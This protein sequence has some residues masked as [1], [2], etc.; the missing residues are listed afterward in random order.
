[1]FH[2]PL[3]HHA[4]RFLAAVAVFV[5]LAVPAHAENEANQGPLDSLSFLVGQ[6]FRNTVD[7]RDYAFLRWRGVPPAAAS[8]YGKPGLPTAAGTFTMAGTLAPQI[9]PTVIATYAN[10]MPAQVFD[11]VS[12][13]NIIDS[14][15]GEFIPAFDL[16]LA[17]KLAMLILLGNDDPR[18]RQR[19]ESLSV[20]EPFLAVCMGLAAV[21]PMP[22]AITTFELR[23]PEAVIARVTVQTQQGS[24]LPAPPAPT[25][26]LESG[27]T[28]HLNVKLRWND[29]ADMLR[30]TPQSFGFDVFRIEKSFAESVDFHL[31]PPAQEIVIALRNDMPGLVKRINEGAILI[32]ART[33]PQASFIADDN[34]ALFGE[35][36]PFA[37]GDAFYYYVAMRD[38]L[39]NPGPLSP[40]TLVTICKRQPPES[41][42]RV[43]VSNYRVTG[44]IVADSKTH[45]RVSWRPHPSAE[46]N[47][48]RGY[49]ISRWT[50]VADI[51]GG[52][53]L[54]VSA[55]EPH[56]PGKREYQF[57]DQEI[58]G[59]AD[60]A[61]TFWYSVE[62][63][64]ET[65]C[66]DLSSGPSAP[67]FG[68]LLDV[69][70][71]NATIGS[72]KASSSRLGINV[73]NLGSVLLTLQNS[74]NFNGPEGG[75]HHISVAVNRG[76]PNV[77]SFSLG[78]A[79]PLV[80]GNVIPEMLA[81]VFFDDDN[82][83]QTINQRIPSELFAENPPLFLWMRA[84]D[85][86]G[87]STYVQ[88]PLS[89]F[90]PDNSRIYLHAVNIT[91][92]S[93]EQFI[94][95]STLAPNDF[96]HRPVFPLTGALNPIELNF[97]PAPNARE[98]KLYK[99]IDGGPRV[100][101][102]QGP[103]SETPGDVLH[104]SDA[105]F[106]PYGGRICYF[107]Q[108]FDKHGNPSPLARLGCV[109]V[110]AK[111]PMPVPILEHAI[112][113][114]TAESPQVRLRWFCPPDGVERFMVHIGSD[115]TEVRR[116]QPNL[117]I[118]RPTFLT[119]TGNVTGSVPP[120]LIGGINFR[121][122]QTGRVGG[123][124]G[125]PTTPGQFEVVLN[126]AP[127]RD[128]QIFI[129]SASS[130]GDLSE[131]SN[132]ES[133]TWGIPTE[134]APA[135]VPWPARM[136]PALDQGFLPQLAAEIID[137]LGNFQGVGIRIGNYN[138][139]IGQTDLGNMG[140]EVG[141]IHVRPPS[142]QQAI[143]NT[144]SLFLTNNGESVFPCV[145]YR[146]E[147]DSDT[148]E[149]VTGDIVQVTPLI[150]GLWQRFDKPTGR[151]TI[152]QPHIGLH[153]NGF[154]TG[155]IY[156]RDAQPV[157]K[158]STYRYLIACFKENGEIDRVLPIKPIHIP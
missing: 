34:G 130:S 124:F 76:N 56:I 85:I 79:R 47:P 75:V 111:S 35:G 27:P 8:I 74:T 50:N 144:V 39:G 59:P 52:T 48:P 4:L 158:G 23:T 65:S 43:E 60:T 116:S 54:A 46:T 80:T 32:P 15:F 9:N 142:Y 102:T 114:G 66:G 94:S 5:A 69:T 95:T 125:D 106:P 13:N 1:M 115:L 96:S 113:E 100:F 131:P 122:Y 67:G 157:I 83:I 146:Y 10:S 154:L 145:V 71:P 92:Q 45:L 149:P 31:Q 53:P 6:P 99:S 58:S 78:Y 20:A 118:P 12:F 73:A 136:L 26:I 119:A 29:H 70:G 152:Y 11:P 140:N 28:G 40:G 2:H 153:N 151:T 68:A 90:A 101:V 93:E 134:D 21:V 150:D 88:Q 110:A 82:P 91:Y 24:G 109:D 36:Q 103:A 129:S 107:V 61:K 128:Y 14:F 49:R 147:F 42:R 62:A 135:L 104:L 89:E 86:S 84:T 81:T 141:N 7:S 121:P 148:G 98:Y 19:L 137:E 123:N 51:A 18:V 16:N 64:E 44:R 138:L 38:L 120:T 126:V 127:G 72:I 30:A 41:P 17:D 22:A 37:D 155:G 63:I 133:F 55:E 87:R 105:S 97:L 143:G 156:I 112:P 25:Q 108:T 139:E 117:T 33:D 132:Q 3:N 77:R 57:I